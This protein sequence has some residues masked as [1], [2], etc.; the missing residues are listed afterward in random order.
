MRAEA[1]AQQARPDDARTVEP[2]RGLASHGPLFTSVTSS[3][4]PGADALE[5]VA[6]HRDLGAARVR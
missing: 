5:A 3:T 4:H 1:D 6:E 2:L